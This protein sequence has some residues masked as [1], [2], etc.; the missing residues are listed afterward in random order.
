MT[1]ITNKQRAVWAAHAV[2]QYATSKE[3]GNELYD[4]PSTVLT[5]MLCDL[6]HH[7]QSSG[8]HFNTCLKLAEHHYE[9]ELKEQLGNAFGLRCPE[10][11]KGD[12]IDIAATVW[13]RLCPDGTD[14]THAANGDHEWCDH[15]GA[16]CAA[17]GHAGNVNE[18]SNSGEPA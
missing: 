10:C 13:V 7:A 14:A 5:D 16:I 3:G 9:E 18:F 1:G 17:C 4:E 11:G 15:S 6:M 2:L 12:E 8:I